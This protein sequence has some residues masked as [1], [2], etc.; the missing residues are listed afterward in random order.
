MAPLDKMKPFLK[1]GQVV[2]S[3]NLISL[4]PLAV[5]CGILSSI[6]LSPIPDEQPKAAA[7]AWIVLGVL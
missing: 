7:I 4:Y 3:T 6:V 2:I 1:E 5:V